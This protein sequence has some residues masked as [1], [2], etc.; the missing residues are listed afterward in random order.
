MKSSPLARALSAG[1]LSVYALLAACQTNPPDVAGYED[2]L[3]AAGF[4]KRIANTPERQSMLRRL[5]IG[6][7]VIRQSGST[8][9][10]VYADPLVC[11]CL[12][13]GTEQAFQQ[14]L[15]NQRSANLASEEQLV[16]QMYEDAGWSW[17]A[18]GPWGSEMGFVYGPMGW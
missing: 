13:L 12:Y 2:K 4:V 18:W 3:A 11:G 8:L 14:Y 9:H 15:Q 1:A 10:Y 16:A 6:Q 7:F 17:A 5:P